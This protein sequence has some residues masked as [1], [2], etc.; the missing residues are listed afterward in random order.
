MAQHQLFGYFHEI[1][2]TVELRDGTP[3]TILRVTGYG[4]PR[5]FVLENGV[6]L[7]K[8]VH[9][10]KLVPPAPFVDSEHWRLG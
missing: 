3:P 9:D 10:V 6:Y 4:A 5:F 8:L 2:G 1:V 7:E